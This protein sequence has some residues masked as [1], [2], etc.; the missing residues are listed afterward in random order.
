MKKANI[1][2]LLIVCVFTPLFSQDNDKLYVHSTDLNGLE[3][4]LKLKDF[5]SVYKMSKT[6]NLATE[7][8]LKYNKIKN[9]ESIGA[10][11]II[12]IPIDKERIK[13]KNFKGASP[14]YYKV[15]EGETLYRIARTYLNQDLNEF[16]DR[17]ELA[18][19]NLKKDAILNLG[20]INFEVEE[21]ESLKADLASEDNANKAGN[22]IKIETG[23]NKSQE[24]IPEVVYVKQRGIAFV[25]GKGSSGEGGMYVLH[26]DAKINSEIELHNPMRKRTVKAKVVGRIPEGTYNSDINVVLSSA[27]A[28]SLGALDS[29]FR[30][31][32]KYIQ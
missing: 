11:Q 15:T 8:I 13:S 4:H 20:Y 21:Q 9:A 31:E 1:I 27:T 32:I 24:L 23:E 17:N 16:I 25:N 28:K 3:I 19:H 10:D 26:P 12:K 2:F 29:R 7:S 30:V 14:V 6:L 18:S 22:E 5:G